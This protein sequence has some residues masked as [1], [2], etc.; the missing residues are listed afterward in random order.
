M[1][2]KSGNKSPSA[3]K[4]SKEAEKMEKKS[5]KASAKD[6]AKGKIPIIEDAAT[7]PTVDPDDLEEQE[8]AAAELRVKIAM[9]RLSQLLA[10]RPKCRLRSRTFVTIRTWKISTALSMKTTLDMKLSQSLMK[11]W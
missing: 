7:A 1:A 4:D 8:D 6:A 5:V 11:S 10:E 3:K 2:P 9:P